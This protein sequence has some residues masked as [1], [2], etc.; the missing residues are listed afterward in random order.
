MEC[1]VGKMCLIVI[2]GGQFGGPTEDVRGDG[3]G[4]SWPWDRL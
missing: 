3:G 1:I 4:R 2:V